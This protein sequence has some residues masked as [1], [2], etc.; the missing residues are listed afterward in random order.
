MQSL[1]F[2]HYLIPPRSKYSPQHHVLKNPQLPFL[3][4]CQRPSFTPIQNNRQNY[5]SISSLNL[6]MKGTL[7]KVEWQI[8]PILTTQFSYSTVHHLTMF[9][10]VTPV[11]SL[12]ICL[13]LYWHTFYVL[14][15]RLLVLTGRIKLGTICT[16]ALYINQWPFEQLFCACSIG[17]HMEHMPIPDGPFLL[18]LIWTV[19]KPG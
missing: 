3:L 17:S 18:L 15:T 2:P 4:Q 5:S 19:I 1:P 14:Y 11:P 10:K 7:P 6:L 9:Q 13:S 8:S 16:L 12:G